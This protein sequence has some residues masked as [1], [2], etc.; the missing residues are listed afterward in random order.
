MPRYRA[1]ATSAAARPQN[2]RMTDGQL[3]QLDNGALA[4][5][6][7]VVVNTWQTLIVAVELPAEPRP[8]PAP[9]R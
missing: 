9:A 6:K 5:V 7:Q 8:V 1:Q 4:Q 2:G 3:V